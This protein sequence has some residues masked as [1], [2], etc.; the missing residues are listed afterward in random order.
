MNSSQI[1]CQ[2]DVFDLN[3][4]VMQYFKPLRTDRLFYSRY[5]KGYTDKQASYAITNNIFN[6]KESKSILDHSLRKPQQAS[7]Q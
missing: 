2:D 5:K 7:V 6:S 3:S 1:T 4:S